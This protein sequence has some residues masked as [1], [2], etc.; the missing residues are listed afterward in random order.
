MALGASVTH[1]MARCAIAPGAKDDVEE[2]TSPEEGALVDESAMKAGLSRK[3]KINPPLE[4]S[5]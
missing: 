5:K 4:P 1:E 3:K 2:E